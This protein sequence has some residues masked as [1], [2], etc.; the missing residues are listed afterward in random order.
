MKLLN[1]T[2]QPQRIPWPL[3]AIRAVDGAHRLN[4]SLSRLLSRASGFGS[5]DDTIAPGRQ[6]TT[7]LV[8]DVPTTRELALEIQGGV[9]ALDQASSPVPT[10]VPPS[11]PSRAPTAPPATAT[12]TPAP[13]ATPEPLTVFAY[14]SGGKR[15]AA[16]RTP[17]GYVCLAPI[18]GTVQVR[19]YQLIDGEV[20][21]GSNVPSLPFFPYLM[22]ESS[23][24]RII[25]RPGALD[26]DTQLLVK[27][28]E[29][30]E[31]GT[32]LFKIVGEGASS[33]RTFYDRGVTANVIVSVSAAPSG[34]ELDPLA[35]F[36]VR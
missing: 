13:G 15:Y 5:I 14:N 18:A 30:T 16:L 10:G 31:P 19:V 8:F 22:L 7:L 29:P 32:P 25:Y 24:R 17:V 4:D 26:A 35:L 23:D 6:I 1:T 2:G 33:W 20:R 11:S 36:T 28:G 21:V 34:V 3:I 12:P 27:D 9:L